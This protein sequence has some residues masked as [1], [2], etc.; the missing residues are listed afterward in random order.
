MVLSTYY[1]TFR[2]LQNTRLWNE[3]ICQQKKQLIAQITA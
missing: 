3:I 2:K 1:Q